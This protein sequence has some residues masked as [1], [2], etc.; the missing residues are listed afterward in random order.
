[1]LHCSISYIHVTIIYSCFLIFCLYPLLTTICCY[2]Y[3]Y[4]MHGISFI[5]L[6]RPV[7][8]KS[9]ILVCFLYIT[10]N[11]KI[12]SKW[13]K[14]DRFLFFYQFGWWGREGSCM[15][16]K[17]SLSFSHYFFLFFVSQSERYMRFLFSLMSRHF[18]QICAYYVHYAGQGQ[19]CASSSVYMFIHYMYLHV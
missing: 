3:M 9:L 5:S 11:R 18:R 8:F 19:V 1:M 17:Y 15:S 6:T 10:I 12:A 4:H 16:Q 14:N 2:M 13:D 7:N